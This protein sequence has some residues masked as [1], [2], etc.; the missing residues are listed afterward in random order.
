MR[1]N[2]SRT[3]S[4]KLVKM[5]NWSANNRCRIFRLCVPDRYTYVAAIHSQTQRQLTIA[6]VKCMFRSVLRYLLT[7]FIICAV[8]NLMSRHLTIY[9]GIERFSSSDNKRFDCFEWRRAAEDDC[10]V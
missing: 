4:D 6:I 9:F 7:N 1:R 5:I 8:H 3:A 10:C 2:N